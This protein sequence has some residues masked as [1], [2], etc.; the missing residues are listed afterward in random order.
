M[1][2][3]RSMTQSAPTKYLWSEDHGFESKHHVIPFGIANNLGTDT[4]FQQLSTRFALSTVNR[5]GCSCSYARTSEQGN[6][7]RQRTFWFMNLCY[8][9]WSP[10]TFTFYFV[11]Y[12]FRFYKA[13]VMTL[14]ALQAQLCATF[15]WS[16]HHVKRYF[17]I[18]QLFEYLILLAM[19]DTENATK[20]NHTCLKVWSFSWFVSADVGMWCG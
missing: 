15:F 11:D 2:S 7:S 20:K 1:N 12:Y 14:C 9:L 10:H 19:S 6:Q 5:C 8:R 4:A 13:Q 18:F 17:Y 16:F 3:W